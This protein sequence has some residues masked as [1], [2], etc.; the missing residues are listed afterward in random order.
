MQPPGVGNL[1]KIYLYIYIYI[2]IYVSMP[3]KYM[4]PKSTKRRME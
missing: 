2:F 1:K 3:I 4:G